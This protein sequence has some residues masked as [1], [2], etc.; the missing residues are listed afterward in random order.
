[1]DN[2]ENKTQTNNDIVIEENETL[3]FDKVSK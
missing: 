2:K 3:Q 1:M